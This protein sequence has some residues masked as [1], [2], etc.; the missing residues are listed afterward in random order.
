MTK[1]D[2]LS[3][4]LSSKRFGSTNNQIME[5][6]AICADNSDEMDGNNNPNGD[7]LG[8]ME[9]SNL[10]NAKLNSRR[11]NKNDNDIEDISATGAVTLVDSCVQE[12]DT[13]SSNHHNS[14]NDD[15]DEQSSRATMS[16]ATP[17]SLPSIPGAFRIEGYGSRTQSSQQQ[18]SFGDSIHSNNSN[19]H[20]IESSI[21]EAEVSV[22]MSRDTTCN[23]TEARINHSEISTTAYVVDEDD[24]E[25]Q[26]VKA[27]V[28]K[29]WY[30]IDRKRFLVMIAVIV[31]LASIVFAIVLRVVSDDRQDSEDTLSRAAATC[32]PL[33]SS[34]SDSSVGLVPDPARQVLG[35]SCEE[36]NKDSLSSNDNLSC[37]E[38]YAPA[39]HGCGCPNTEIPSNGCGMLCQ[40]NS[41]LPD[42]DRIVRDINGMERTC[43]EWQL[44]SQFD[45]STTNQS[46]SCAKYDAVGALCGCENNLPQTDTCGSLCADN[47]MP[48]PEKIVWRQSCEEWNILSTFLPI[49]QATENQ[50]DQ[51]QATATCSRYFQDIAYRCECPESQSPPSGCNALCQQRSLCGPSLCK[52]GSVIPYPDKIVRDMTCREWDFYS[53]LADHQEMCYFYDMVGAECGCV[54]NLPP[55]NACGPLCEDS[56]L[57]H[58]NHKVNGQT[59]SEWNS[60]S[61]FL[62]EGYGAAMPSTTSMI[63]SCESFFSPIA[64]GCDCPS[65]KPPL[66][67]CGT[68]CKDGSAV[69]DPGLI[70]GDRTCED[71]E[72]KSL[73]ETDPNFCFRY[74]TIIA[75]QC[76][77][78]EESSSEAD[79]WTTPGC[80]SMED[81]IGKKFYYT[82]GMSQY[83][84]S[85]GQEGKFVQIQND[86]SFITIGKFNGFQNNTG[87]DDADLSVYRASYGGGYRC[88]QYGPRRGSVV[89]IEDESL[90]VP[91]IS[92][93]IEP[94]TCV[95]QATLKI[96]KLC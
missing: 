65:V 74:N 17:S 25:V 60:M 91:E 3:Q 49:L 11:D 15:N 1:D 52:D 93:V 75:S 77:C 34:S 92:G 29:T 67:G 30:G 16:A 86:D 68:L 19:T 7:P 37:Q 71:Y 87:V 76:G 96:P 66:D 35:R 47:T 21:L 94:S 90:K 70:V 20:D 8:K 40:D 89:L 73:F 4:E 27:T 72:L 80:F 53:R 56:I 54:G 59:C 36:W 95:Y 2:A 42:P 33:C 50:S 22:S 63:S 62:F 44:L 14:S 39:A 69:P 18:S 84:V 5:T 13:K 88:G 26:G 58:P 57:P 81:L 46:S 10:Y 83:S 48:V 31:V 45:S 41:D 24:V 82:I 79:E 32:G 64:F 78:K 6:K 28:V 23:S 9:S 43:S 55:P 61:N 38:R 12:K 51:E 85:F